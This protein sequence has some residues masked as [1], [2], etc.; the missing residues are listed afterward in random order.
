MVEPVEWRQDEGCNMEYKEQLDAGQSPQ[1]CM[2]APAWSV[3]K[4][5]SGRGSCDVSTTPKWNLTRKYA[6]WCWW[7]W[8]CMFSACLCEIIFSLF[9]NND[10]WEEMFIKVN[11][12]FIWKSDPLYPY[13]SNWLH[14]LSVFQISRLPARKKQRVIIERTCLFHSRTGIIKP[15]DK[16][17][18]F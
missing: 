13:S 8:W 12:K 6:W 17:N 4:T 16:C 15:K 5:P 11:L 1:L 14:M 2:I 18:C 10:F 7:W 9:V 3:P